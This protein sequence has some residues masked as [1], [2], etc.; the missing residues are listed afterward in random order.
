MKKIFICILSCFI[1]SLSFGDTHQDYNIFI[2]GKNAYYSGDFNTAKKDFETL[3]RTF[4]SSAVFDGNYAYFFI[5]MTYYELKDYKN[6]ALYLEKAVY[7]PPKALFNKDMDIEKAIF[8]SERDYSLG[9]SLIKIGEVEKGITY[10]KRLDYS[11]YF[12]IVADYEEK[13][14]KLLEKYSPEAKDKMELKF[15][16]DFSKIKNM[17][18]SEL[19]KIGKFYS[20][21]KNYKKAEEF[22]EYILKNIELN[23]YGE[24]INRQYLKVLIQLK[25]YKKIIEFTNN[26]P[27]KYKDLF[28]FYRGLAYYQMKDFT[29]A[30]FL[31]D[32]IKSKNYISNA[33][34]YSAG[35]YFAL[36]DYKS[37]IENATKI[38]SKTIIS[39]TMLAFSY[40]YLNDRKM[41]EET[42][43]EIIKR[44]SN[45]Y[46]ATY[47]QLLLENKSNIPTHI[48]SLHDLSI[49]V[50]EIIKNGQ[51][52]P[53]NFIKKADLLEMEQLSEIAKYGDRELLQL[54]FDRGSFFNHNSLAYG[55]STTLVLETGE[56]YSLAFKNSM[57]YMRE[58]L[59]Y[60]E[61]MKYNYPLYFKEIVNY[62]SKKYDVPQEMIY[63]IMHNISQFNIY[64]VSEDSKF[65]I[66]GISYSPNEKYTLV[67]IFDPKI[68]MEIGT[69]ILRKYLDKYEGNKL[70]ALIAYINGEKYLTSLYFNDNN[71]LS[72]SSIIIPEER[73]FLEN[74]FLTYVFYSKLYEF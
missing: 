21:Q 27:A 69:S 26:P 41:F 17:P 68:N 58:L 33:K 71:D 55:Y 67:E 18:I 7:I 22:Y 51:E 39:E 54:S 40:L 25:E 45:T 31:F 63:T 74:I 38:T 73:Y 35:I 66:M 50:A 11:T 59:N 53:K 42:A 1:Y 3:L 6:A 9:D 47:F 5:G 19:I 37:T 8:F 20:S 13:A 23:N 29:R 61:L 48:T 46:V 64:F 52:L 16:F 36:G 34:Y 62:C 43:K 44:Y 49:I 14:L 2:E 4:S 70:K 56:F 15:N 57:N 24:E 28:N 65:G 10:L 60:K 30:L 32:E 72:F 12:P